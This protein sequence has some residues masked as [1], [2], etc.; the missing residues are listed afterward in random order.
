MNNHENK[1]IKNQELDR[2]VLAVAGTF[3]YACGI[4]FFISPERLNAGGIMGYC[5]LIRTLMTDYFGMNFGMLDI[6]GIIYYI[7]NIPIFFLAYRR[8]GRKFFVKTLVCVTTLSFFMSVLPTPVKPILD[9]TLACCLIGGILNGI[10]I[11]LTLSMGASSGGMDVVGLMLIQWRHNLSVG[12]VT[13]VVNMVL[14]ALCLMMFSLPVV[15]Y[16][17][18]FAA[19][20]SA[21]VDRTHMQNINAEVTIITR[22]DCRELE[23]QVFCEL[24]RGIT[25]WQAQG[26][27]TDAPSD[28]LYIMCS[29]YE[30]NRLKQ[31]V[32]GY[33]K[34]AFIIVKEG[35]NVDGN[36]LKK[37]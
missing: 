3:L 28:I 36:F 8:I 32:K 9:D 6:A 15:I 31:I 7:V 22:R 34:D 2:M 16:S 27:Y 33:D 24:G 35:V 10:G 37:L 19:A 20:A 1:K 21:A 25:R 23:Q 18:I 14:Y 17:L 12:K 13:L 5:Q 11:G 29:K 26:A 30:V 4:N